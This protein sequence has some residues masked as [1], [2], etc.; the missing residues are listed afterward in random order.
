MATVGLTRGGDVT[1]AHCSGT[2]IAD[3]VVLTAGHCAE[4]YDIQDFRVL[5]GPT[6]VGATDYRLVVDGH[7]HPG[8]NGSA[9]LNDIALLR[10]DSPADDVTA[11][12]PHL[13][14]E[15]GL[16][17]ADE[18]ATTVDFSGFG[19][20]DADNY[21]VK[22]H[23]EN[24]I[25]V[26]CDGPEVC[27]RYFNPLTMGYDHDPGG[28]CFGDSGG[29]AYVMRGSDEYVAG[30]SSYVIGGCYDDAASTMAD[31]FS[32][33]IDAY[34]IPEDCANGV[35]D[36]FDALTD[37]G[38]PECDGDP[39]CPEDCANGIDD[40][41]DG[42]TDCDDADCALHP[43]CLPDA[44]EDAEVINC[45]D[46]A[47]ANTRQGTQRFYSYGCMTTGT[48]DGPE[49]AYRLDAPEATP[50]TVILEHTL[51]SDLDLF[52]LP[53][54]AASCDTATCLDSSLEG[55]PPERL[56]FIMPADGAYLVVE[57]YD[58]PNS[59]EL[60]VECGNPVELCGDGLDNDGDGDTDCDD[61]DCKTDLACLGPANLTVEPTALD[62][63]AAQNAG[64]PVP[65]ITLDNSGGPAVFSIAAS[66]AWLDPLPAGGT[67]KQLT[68]RVIQVRMDIASLGL[69]VHQGS[70][71]ITAE[72]AIGS[73]VTVPVSLEVVADRPV[74]PVTDLQIQPS[75]QALNVTWTTPSDPIVHRVI[76]RRA[77]GTPP[78]AP[79]VGEEVYEGLGQELLDGDLQNGTTYCYSAFAADAAN[80][81]A[82]PASACAMPGEN[83]P[84]PVPELLSPTDGASLTGAPTLVAS[85]VA[86][87]E[88][89][90][91]TY[92]FQLLANNAT[93]VVDTGEGTVSGNRVEWVP[94]Y[95]LQPETVY[96]WQVE[97]VDSQDEHSGFADPRSFSIRAP[98]PDAGVDGG[99][100][101]EDPDSG[102]GC[103]S[104]GA[105]SNPFIFAILFLLAMIICNRR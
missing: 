19:R 48:E 2:L 62:I 94:T 104:T 29:P 98:Q 102:C 76:V 79:D 77:P 73:P 100:P 11:P 10:L 92:T 25:N 87:P 91:V 20:D 83:R 51:G 32:D 28:P 61:E 103:N 84:P 105:A 54:A 5:F 4:G 96:H 27:E 3:S 90:A 21:G 63:T 37:C 97:A 30:I 78:A 99:T 45:G 55:R 38:D 26:V 82:D 39:A 80:R 14:A 60:S 44:C 56:D 65:E 24:L 70:L 69:G 41:P 36:D 16:N 12:I 89:D 71:E 72:G 57:T 67:L 68:S 49:L 42:D 52:V 31:R 58:V 13:P 53:A 35:D 101:P 18:G 23:V 8:Y 1:R 59:F 7:V 9:I 66:Q 33:W 88:G 74:P 95:D 93:S 50:V 64:D 22:L 15:L 43:L 47:I 75:D 86:D 85:T 46:T 40:E 81:Y 6:L 17:Q 34:I